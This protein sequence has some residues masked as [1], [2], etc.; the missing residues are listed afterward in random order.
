[1]PAFEQLGDYL[2]G[3]DLEH[4]RI[5]EEAS[6]ADQHVLE[7]R[8]HLARCLLE[9][10]DVI[11]DP[12]DLVDGHAPFDAAADRAWLV[13]REVV[14]GPRPQQDEDLL[15]RGLQFG[16]HQ[17][18]G[19]W[20]LAESVRG[21]G[22]EPGGHLGRRQ[23]VVHHAGGDRAA[24]HAVEFGG[25]GGL[26]HDHASLALDGAHAGRAIAAGAGEDDADRPLVQVLGERVE[27][28]IDRKALAAGF[29]G[30]QQLQRP[31]KKRHVPPRWYDVNAVDLHSHPVLDFEHLHAGVAPYEVAKNARV[32]RCQMLHE[33][34]R[35][36]RVGIGWHAREK[37]LECG[38]SPGRRA[39]AHDGEIQLGSDRWRDRRIT[40][41]VSLPLPFGGR[42]HFPAD[43]LALFQAFIV[44]SIPSQCKGHRNVTVADLVVPA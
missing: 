38:Q 11:L 2:V 8:I 34:K 4:L 12:L 19:P 14:A 16:R 24:R 33:H 21:I 13:F 1:M 15:H 42:G 39:D 37:C 43:D 18:P 36:A 17:G 23:L 31:A 41:A 29:G 7:Q 40:I 30:L 20:K 22:N 28:K 25:G 26:G 3:Q 10:M 44:G 6:H 9:K 32:V 5:A 35:H 27:E